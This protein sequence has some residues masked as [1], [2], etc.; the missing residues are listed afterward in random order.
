M[1]SGVSRCIVGK[2]LT[3]SVCKHVSVNE[4]AFCYAAVHQIRSLCGLRS[5]L[6]IIWRSLAFKR[7]KHAVFNISLDFLACNLRVYGIQATVCRFWHSRWSCQSNLRRCIDMQ[8]VARRTSNK[9]LILKHLYSLIRACFIAVFLSWHYITDHRKALFFYYMLFAIDYICTGRFA[10]S[11]GYWTDLYLQ[12]FVR[13]TGERKAPE[14]NRGE[15]LLLKHLPLQD[16]VC[17]CI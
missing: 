13:Q 7:I 5:V 12:Y 15:L 6:R 17:N 2:A 3:G 1:R 14:I 10:T 9:K 16:S 11:K 4:S 8:K